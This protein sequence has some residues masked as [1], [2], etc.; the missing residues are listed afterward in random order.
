MFHVK[1]FRG[2]FAGKRFTLVRRDQMRVRGRAGFHAS[3]PTASLAYIEADCSK[4]FSRGIPT[5]GG[6]AHELA[7]PH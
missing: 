4:F 2:V 3:R 7:A 5:E 6:G 1:H